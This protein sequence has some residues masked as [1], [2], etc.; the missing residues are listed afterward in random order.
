MIIFAQ[1][2]A[3]RNYLL[4]FLFIMPFRG[5]SQ[6]M[7]EGV[8]MP[9]QLKVAGQNILLNGG[10]VREKYFLDLYVAGLYL[11]APSS[12]AAK[13]IAADEPMAI[14]I[15]IVS[16][17]I[18]SEKMTAAVDEGFKKSAGSTLS[19]L[20]TRINQFKDVFK[21]EIKKGD[22]YDLIY[23][24]GKGCLIMK[25]NKLT[26]SISGLDFKKGLFGIWLCNDPAQESLK[27]AMLKK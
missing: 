19:S 4:L 14:R 18:T 22:V 8:S 24:P 13:I 23:E 11:K 7:I 6:T 21:E 27:S 17:L 9:N 15:H 20:Q 1:K 25:N 3:M 5:F 16:G 26:T 2:L 12:D 10:G